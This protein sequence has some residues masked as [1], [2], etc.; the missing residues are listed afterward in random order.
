MRVNDLYFCCSNIRTDGLVTFLEDGKEPLTVEL[1]LVIF[2][3]FD[4]KIDWFSVEDGVIIIKLL[5]ENNK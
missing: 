1:G 5:K 4:R 2:E 3:F